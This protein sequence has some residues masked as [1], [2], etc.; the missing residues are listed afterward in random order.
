V[1]LELNTE[2]EVSFRVAR[3][4]DRMI[5]QAFKKVAEFRCSGL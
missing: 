2:S 4:Q 5:Q 3:T 1:G